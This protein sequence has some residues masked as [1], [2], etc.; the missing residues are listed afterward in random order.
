M[1]L[2][3]QKE[4]NK[5]DGVNFQLMLMVLTLVWIALSLDK[6]ANK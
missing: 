1:A 2:K 3:R 5:M 6:I 4:E